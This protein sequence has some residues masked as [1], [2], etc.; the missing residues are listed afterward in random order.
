MTLLRRGRT[1]LGRIGAGLIW[2]LR[3]LTG[4]ADYDRYVDHCRLHGSCVTP[5]S[6][7]QFERLKW[8]DRAASPGTRC[9]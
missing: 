7:Q 9:C 2:Y 4:E 1:R 6:R 5:V 8:E 3:E